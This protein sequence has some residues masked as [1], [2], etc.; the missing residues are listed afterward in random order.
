MVAQPICFFLVSC[1]GGFQILSKLD[2]DRNSTEEGKKVVDCVGSKGA[3]SCLFA[4]V[5]VN[6][7]VVWSWS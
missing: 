6:V 3:R 2:V 4:G 5:F 1:A 7:A